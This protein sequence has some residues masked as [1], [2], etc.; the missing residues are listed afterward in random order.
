MSNMFLKRDLEAEAKEA[1]PIGASSSGKKFKMPKPPAGAP[2]PR[3]LVMSQ[4]Q[5]DKASADLKE[6]YIVHQC[7]C[8]GTS[9][10]GLAQVRVR[11]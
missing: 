9:P 1:V 7:N 8:I 11:G 6:Q 10:K 3:M 4:Q 5:A 2:P